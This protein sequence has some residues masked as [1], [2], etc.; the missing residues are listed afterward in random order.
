MPDDRSNHPPLRVSGFG[1]CMI[2]GYPHDSG[3][4]FF[5]VACAHVEED[6]SC[7]VESKI[8]SFGGFPAPRAEKYLAEKVIGYTPNYII[9]QLAA[10]DA[11]CPVRQGRL[12]FG[13]IS[14]KKV[15]SPARLRE[16]DDRNCRKEASPSSW[17]RWKLASIAGYLQR[18]EPTTSL[19]AY[20]PVMERMIDAC[21][22]ADVTPIVLTPFIYGSRYSM[23]SGVTYANALREL[24]AKKPGAVL[25]DCI[26]A[27]R[28]HPKHA[29]L[30]HD[31]FHLSQKGHAVVGLA[32]A[33]Q[34]TSHF[35]LL[36]RRR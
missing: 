2:S 35:R 1:A 15:G 10:L 13:G 34:I 32:V 9:I 25:V 36:Q 26:E 30:Q 24:I 31:G 5:N 11:L 4:G 6:L 21:M 3:A 8:F 22:A 27:L 18:L 17:M 16:A 20:M 33:E 7:S 12:Y 23:R 29:I 14:G 28:V 19:S